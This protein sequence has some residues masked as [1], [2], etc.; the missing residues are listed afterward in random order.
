M[1][2][3]HN[4]V[5]S[6]CVSN[7]NIKQLWI[8]SKVPPPPSV[9]STQLTTVCLFLCTIKHIKLNSVTVTVTSAATEHV[10]ALHS[11]VYFHVSINYNNSVTHYQA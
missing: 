7:C 5:Y 1:D 10:D 8:E 9:T 2:Q 6:D 4:P 3:E 11:K